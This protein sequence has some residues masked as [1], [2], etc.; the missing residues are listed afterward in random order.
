VGLSRL[1][2]QN[3]RTRVSQAQ[4]A[5][6]ARLPA[7]PPLP[8]S[9][10]RRRC[11]SPGAAAV[12]YLPAPPPFP[13]SRHRRRCCPSHPR[14][15]LEE[16]ASVLAPWHTRSTAALRPLAAATRFIQPR[17]EDVEKVCRQ[18]PSRAS[19]HSGH[20][21]KRHS[22]GRSRRQREGGSR[23]DSAGPASTTIAPTGGCAAGRT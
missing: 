20:G 23:R 21:R 19:S 16:H 8:V 15:A 14:A 12:S 10:C 22:R 3:P 9:R 13:T 17:D 11:T 4:A 18:G 5:A 6:T 2:K 7:P 1:G